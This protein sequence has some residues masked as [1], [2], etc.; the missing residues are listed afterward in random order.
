MNTN[1]THTEINYFISR[2][3]HHK[4][5]C[6]SHCC[7]TLN[8]CIYNEYFSLFLF[9]WAENDF[10]FNGIKMCGF[11]H[12]LFDSAVVQC[13]GTDIATLKKRYALR[14]LASLSSSAAAEA[15]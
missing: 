6:E 3:E 5:N 7:F 12:A 4:F 11:S 14:M 9:I 2:A 10:A 13:D 8:I 1:N 15:L